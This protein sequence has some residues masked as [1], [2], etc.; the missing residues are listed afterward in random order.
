MLDGRVA[1]FENQ[2]GQGKQWQRHLIKS[3]GHMQDF[4]SIC[5]ADFDNDGDLDIFSGG[6]P[7]TRGEHQWFIW[8]NPDG[9]GKAWKEHVIVRGQRT[10]ESVCADVDDD[11]DVDILTKPWN[12]RSPSFRRERDH[13]EI[14]GRTCENPAKPRRRQRLREDRHFGRH[15]PDRADRSGRP[16]RHTYGPV[17][18]DAT[19]HE[20][21]GGPVLDRFVIERKIEATAEEI[22]PFRNYSR[23]SDEKLLRELEEKLAKVKKARPRR[24]LPGRSDGVGEGASGTRT[25]DFADA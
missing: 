17:G 4:H 13:Q 3:P 9:K 8:E 14:S 18:A 20:G 19:G 15:R 5:V 24:D 16:V 21:V 25:E 11:G 23:R 2:D 7:L 1:W 12:G 6:G 22:K 10:H